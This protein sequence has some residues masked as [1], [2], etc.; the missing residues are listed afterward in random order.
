MVLPSPVLGVPFWAV[1]AGAAVVALLRDAY[2]GA[3]ARAVVERWAARHEYRLLACRRSWVPAWLAGFGLRNTGDR[4]GADGVPRRRY[5]YL[6]AVVVADGKLGGRSRARV[7]V[8]GDWAAGFD[9]DVDVAWDEM[10]APDP[11][12]AATPDAGPTWDA[13]QLA[14]LRRVGAGES[15]FRPDDRHTP[16]AGERFDLVVEHLQAMQRRGLVDFPAP[17]AEIGRPGRL[18]GAVTDVA[19]TAAGR[20]VLAR[21]G[22]PAA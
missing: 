13:A 15:T 11:T 1:A 10:N 21:A 17:L 8:E 22:E 18:Y 16:E 19:L 5:V 20:A 2:L 6:F 14:L 3:Q 12:G 9:D 4:L 7:R